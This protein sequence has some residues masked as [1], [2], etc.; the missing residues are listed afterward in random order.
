MKVFLLALGLALA[1]A[2][3]APAAPPPEKFLPDNTEMVFCAD[4]RTLLDSPLAK[5]YLTDEV[6]KK[7]T[8]NEKLSKLMASLNFDPL[9][10]VSQVTVAVAKFQV[11]GPGA[12]PEAEAMFIVRG[13]FD[14]EKMTAGVGALI[15]ADDNAKVATS[16]YGQFTIYERKDG[17]GKPMYATILDKD[18]ILAGTSKDFVTDGIERGLGKKTGSLSKEFKGVLAKADTKQP[19]W[20]ALSIPSSVK[21]MAKSQ[22][23]GEVV[24]K[25]A[26]ITLGAGVGDSITLSLNLYATDAPTAAQIK[27]GFMQAKEFMGVM[28]L[29]QQ[30]FGA[31]L[32]DL[33]NNLQIAES[34]NMVSMKA[35]VKG[36]LIDKL[37]KKA[38]AGGQ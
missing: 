7:L 25:I 8:G 10:D 34:N 28:A 32:S 35:E 33:I 17:G 21:D 30:E 6:K 4:V 31:E 11:T 5:K 37:V 3:A 2:T 14:V 23:Q 16:T 13:K 26:A 12:P 1:G 22:P 9:R 24:E 27:A 36:D 15:A 29:Q 19:F 20:L 18:T 38:K